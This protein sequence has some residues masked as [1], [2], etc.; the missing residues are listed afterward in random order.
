MKQPRHTPR[1]LYHLAIYGS[2]NRLIHS[3]SSKSLRES[4]RLAG[5]Y[6]DEMDNYQRLVRELVRVPGAYASAFRLLPRTELPENQ[7]TCVVQL[8]GVD[9][10]GADFM[11]PQTMG[12]QP[13]SHSGS[14][15]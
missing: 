15:S 5:L 10:V 14:T 9:V 13:S 2:D 6:V 8:L 3:F 7:T 11:F 4:V 12:E 1:K